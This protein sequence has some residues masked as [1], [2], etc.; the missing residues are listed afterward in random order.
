MNDS[1][2]TEGEDFYKEFVRDFVNTP[3]YWE[4][5]GKGEGSGTE[6]GIA[7]ATTKYRDY[8][9]DPNLR[10][11]IIERIGLS[12]ELVHLLS[13]HLRTVTKR[14]FRYIA[15][16]DRYFTCI[17][18]IVNMYCIYYRYL[19]VIDID[20]KDGG[21]SREE[22]YATLIER[23]KKK[24]DS[25]MIYR[26]RGGYHVFVTNK[27]VHYA[28]REATEYMIEFGCDPNYIVH[29]H[30]AGWCIRLNK[31]QE[32]DPMYTYIQSIGTDHRYADDVVVHERLSEMFEKNL[33]Y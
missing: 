21:I 32:D 3:T 22:V 12:Y 20:V 26:T 16:T 30:M 29:A 17:D 23:C 4:G 9:Y 33:L 18:M 1:S 31:K 10:K 6:T 8:L 11:R 19:I 7:T 24:G 28:S 5:E 27:K 25:Y 13:E 2:T 15:S 14:S